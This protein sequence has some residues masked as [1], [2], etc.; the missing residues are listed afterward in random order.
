MPNQTAKG[1]PGSPVVQ[2]SIFLANRVGQLGDMVRLMADNKVAVLGMSVIDSADWAVI[3]VVFDD[4]VKARSLL[5]AHSLPFTESGVLLVE[6]PDDQALSRICSV[7]L[8]AEIN[9]HF[10]YPLTI[11]SNEHPIYI[12][13]VDDTSLASETL[14]RHEFPVLGQDDLGKE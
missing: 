14:C 6:L 8:Q 9:V 2:F 7:L 10:A 1:H 13:H 4:S 5:Q 11:R 12:F 3:R